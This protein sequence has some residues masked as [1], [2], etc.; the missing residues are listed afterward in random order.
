MEKSLSLI[1]VFKLE[2]WCFGRHFVLQSHYHW[3]KW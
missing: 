3:D 1:Y 2:K